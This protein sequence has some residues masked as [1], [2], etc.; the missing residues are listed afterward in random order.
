MRQQAQSL[1]IKEKKRNGK[2]KKNVTVVTTTLISDGEI[3]AGTA[4]KTEKFE[5]KY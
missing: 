5:T 4:S 2:R 3:H 1:L